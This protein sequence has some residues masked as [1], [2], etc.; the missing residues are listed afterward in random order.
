MSMPAMHEAAISLYLKAHSA[1][2]SKAVK[3]KATATLKEAAGFLRQRGAYYNGNENALKF[4]D[5][6]LRAYVAGTKNTVVVTN[7]H[8]TD[9]EF[10]SSTQLSG[11]RI[12]FDAVKHECET[13]KPGLGLLAIFDVVLVQSDDGTT[14]NALDWEP[15]KLIGDGE[16]ADG[17]SG[18]EE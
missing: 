2:L 12:A 15:Q 17:Q 9:V 13:G 8:S 10:I 7:R 14:Y 4:W 6:I 1:D 11:T 16:D 3:R 5:L 18:E